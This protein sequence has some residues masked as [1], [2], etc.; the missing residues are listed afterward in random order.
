MTRWDKF[1]ASLTLATLMVLLVAEAAWR[2]LIEALGIVGRR[3]R[4][5]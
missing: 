2:G 3:G 1:V 4:Q 5:L